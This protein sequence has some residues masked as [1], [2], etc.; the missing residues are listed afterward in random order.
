MQ[1]KDL[2]RNMPFRDSKIKNLAPVL[3]GG[4]PHRKVTLYN[5]K[6]YT[7]LVSA[8]VE[9]RGYVEPFPAAKGTGSLGRAKPVHRASRKDWRGERDGTRQDRTTARI[10]AWNM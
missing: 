3:L 6:T 1:V 5:G 2:T 4:V 8:K 10:A 7:L 9:T